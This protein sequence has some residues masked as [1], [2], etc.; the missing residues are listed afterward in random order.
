MDL[1]ETQAPIMDW[2]SVNLPEDDETLQTT[3]K[4]DVQWPSKAQT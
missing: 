3:Y 1:A 2:S 4:A